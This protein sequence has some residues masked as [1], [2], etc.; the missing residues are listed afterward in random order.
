MNELTTNN[1]LSQSEINNIKTTF[2][3]N[4][5][6]WIKTPD[7][8]LG[9]SATVYIDEQNL[10]ETLKTLNFNIDYIKLKQF[11]STFLQINHYYIFT[12]TIT[13]D[14]VDKYYSEEASFNCNNKHIDWLDYNGFKV[15]TKPVKIM[16]NKINNKIKMKGDLDIELAIYALK[17]NH[18]AEHIII[19]TG[20]GD[21]SPLVDE[22]QH[23]GKI[24]TIISTTKSKLVP[25]SD[26][27]LRKTDR[28][29]DLENLKPYIMRS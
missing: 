25:I 26:D 5:P 27:L 16:H 6:D 7:K 10:I 8:P 15:I 29:I 12:P 4:F 14:V 22:L 19:F 24:I 2:L 9:P 28:F 1:L 17:Y 18:N 13:K 3:K 23:D 21:F 11:F 20:D